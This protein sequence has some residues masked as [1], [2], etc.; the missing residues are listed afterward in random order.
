[1]A[2]WGVGLPVVFWWMSVSIVLIELRNWSA[3]LGFIWFTTSMSC[4]ALLSSLA[5]CRRSISWKSFRPRASWLLASR[6]MDWEAKAPALG[7]CLLASS[8]SML[9]SSRAVVTM[10]ESGLG[11]K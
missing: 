1:A 11:R 8:A 5:L 10:A 4:R 6:A 9:L 7:Y 3:N 2:D